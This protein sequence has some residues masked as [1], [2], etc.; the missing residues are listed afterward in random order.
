MMQTFLYGDNKLQY[1]REKFNIYSSDSDT[2]SILNEYKIKSEYDRSALYFSKQTLQYLKVV[3][4]LKD[5]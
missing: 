3:N 2:T 1:L 5:I 4:F